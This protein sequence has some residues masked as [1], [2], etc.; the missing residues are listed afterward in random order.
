[1]DNVETSSMSPEKGEELSI[2]EEGQFSDDDMNDLP[3]TN[4]KNLKENDTTEDRMT[5]TE[6]VDMTKISS[7]KPEQYT[8]TPTRILKLVQIDKGQKTRF[9]LNMERGR[10]I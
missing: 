10:G 2:M 4:D 3:S 6:V 7:N 1:M 8:E 5:V 9:T